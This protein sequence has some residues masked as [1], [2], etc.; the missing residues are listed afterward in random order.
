MRRLSALGELL[1]GVAHELN[2]PLSVVLGLSLMLKE[3]R[4]R[5]QDRRARRQDQQGGRA[6]RAHRQ[7]VPGHG[8]AAADADLQR[9]RS[10][11]SSPRPSRWPAIPSDRPTSSLAIHAGAEPSADLGRSG[12]A[13]P[14]PDQSPRQCR[15]GAARLERPT[16]DSGLGQTPAKSGN[17]VVK[18]ADT[19]P[20]I[21]KEILPRIFEPFFTTKEVGAGTG[22]GLSF[23]HRIVQSHGGTI[24][25]ETTEGGGS[26][27]IVSLPASSRPGEQ[28]EVAQ[29]DLARSA[30]LACLVVD[31]ESEVG[32]M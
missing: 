9:R 12:S 4:G 20:G 25:V 27:F 8:E 31:D 15:A 22:I 10:T 16:Q 18:V 1:A 5:R 11:T 17:I 24:E 28:V 3:A 29:H 21:P 30:G 7:D 6:L 2:N 14:G 19:G 32:E 13:Q 23:C 26:T